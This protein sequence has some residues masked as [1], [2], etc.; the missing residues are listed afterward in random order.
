MPDR[1]GYC[2]ARSSTSSRTRAASAWPAHRL[3][4]GADHGAGGLH[5]AV[6]DLLEH[7]GLRGQRLVDRGDERAVVRDDGEPAGVDDLLRRALAGDDA[8]EH[9]AGE[10]VGERAG[11]DERCSAATSAG[12][13]RSAAS[14]PCAFARRAISPVHHLRAAAGVAPAATVASTSAS[15]PPLATSWNSR[16]VKPHAALQ[17]ATAHGRR[18][19][20]RG[21]QLLDQ[22]ERR[23][24]GQQVG[25]GEVAV[26]VGVA[27]SGG[28]ARS[29]RC[30][31][32]SAGSPA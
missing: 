19:G 10:L 15:R 1:R 4:D 2:A 28:P 23:L 22:L 25:L 8:L 27:T 21:A 30:P 5:L 11:V 18:L 9:L 29:C 12:V 20:Q 24:D 26:V 6:A 31:R 13:T 32:A 16:S 7:V 17:P 14:R 3:H